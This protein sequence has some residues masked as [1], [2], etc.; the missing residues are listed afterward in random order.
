GIANSFD[1]QKIVPGLAISYGNRET[2]VA[3][4]GVSNNVRS[5]GS[6]PSNAV[7][8]DGVYLPQSS[9][10]LTDL[11]D[12]ARVE[13]LK[14]PQGTL[15][16]RNATGGALN[17]ISRAPTEGYSAEGFVGVGSNSL[18][19]GQVALNGGSDTVA[20]RFALSYVK[21]DGY[22]RNVLRGTDLDAQDFVG[23]RGSV[24][25]QLSPI[26]DLTLLAHVTRDDGTVGYGISTDAAFKSFP[27][28]FYAV[29]VPANLQR[30]DE[31]NIRI[32]APVFNHRDSD[33][34]AAT[35][36]WKI[37]DLQLKS[38]T[39]VTKYRAN[40]A[41]DFDFTGD[42]NET[43]TSETNVDSKS[44][45]LQLSNASGG[46]L[47]WTAG[48]YFYSD[49]ADQAVDWRVP[50]PFARATTA[51]KGK[52]KA[53]FGQATYKFADKWAVMAGA[54]YNEDEKKG[55]Q[56]NLISSTTANVKGKFDSF[57]PQVQLQYRP[58]SDVLT[59]IGVSQGFKSGG[60]NLLAAGPPT[61]YDP[62]EIVAYEA[63][64]R[65][66]LAD[67]KATF[68]ASI[69][70]YDYTDLQ[71]R[72]LVFTGTGGGAFATVNN[73]EG[74]KITGVELNTD[75]KLGGG[76]S[77]DLNATY[78]D[79][80]FDRYISPSNNL[81]LSGTRL[82]LS[83]EWSGSAG[84]SYEG[85]LLGGDVRARVEYAYRGEII[86]PLTIDAPQNFDASSGVVNATARW[87]APNGG[88]YVE[89]I[90]RNLGDDLYRVQR[91]DVFFS[92]VY[93]SFGPPRTGEIRLG[94]NF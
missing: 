50:F 10:I 79:A 72:T 43:F 90:G 58:T 55:N 35:L 59:Y 65:S 24:R 78:L 60:F 76:F 69:F 51:S 46:N 89:V 85:A 80:T 70:H 75:L 44:Q 42:P 94:F 16:G 18:V 57:T 41:L 7:H 29:V 15:Y 40:D 62:E 28:N 86:F 23:G 74:A 73:A 34:Y 38:I 71:L 25:F 26:V 17:V 39:G 92:G 54:R 93:D 81:D 84:V 22:T 36:N 87:T 11:F 8:L 63:G 68:N 45:E 30:I 13:V 14:G 6:D 47:E 31:R 3:I 33:V 53:I 21:D 82:P 4:R 83:P 67:G 27:A 32:D 66:T 2:N 12:V 61:A 56:R 5:V 91:A 52:S 1:L 64:L 9:M 88:Y 19:R 37:G 48:L 49:D 20:G 77:A